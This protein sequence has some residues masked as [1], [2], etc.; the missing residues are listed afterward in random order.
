MKLPIAEL[1]VLVGLW[2]AASAAIPLSGT[3]ALVLQCV[4][5]GEHVSIPEAW[6][7][8]TAPDR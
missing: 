2:Y 4:E 5:Y 7:R 3:V 6:G 8:C 1:C